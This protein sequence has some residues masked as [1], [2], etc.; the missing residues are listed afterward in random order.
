MIGVEMERLVQGSFG[1]VP[2]RG[3]VQIMATGGGLRNGCKRRT[4]SFWK[5]GGRKEVMM[6]V[7]ESAFAHP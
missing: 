6:E 1:V 5:S 2:E 4:M 7:M 3:N